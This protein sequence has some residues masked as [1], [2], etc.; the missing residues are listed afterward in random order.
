MKPTRHVSNGPLPKSELSASSKKY[1]LDIP[2]TQV[3]SSNIKSIGY[4]EDSKALTVEFHSGDIWYYY[5][6]SA[7]GYKMVLFAESIGKAFNEHIK[8]NPSITS[9]K[10]S[11]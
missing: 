10:I 8:T 1:Y 7:E 2:R 6:V 11:E 4:T 9:F 3:E 5:P